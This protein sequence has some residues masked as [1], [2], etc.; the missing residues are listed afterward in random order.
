MTSILMS[1]FVNGTAF[2]FIFDLI[3]QQISVM[4]GVAWLF[5]VAW[6]VFLVVL[7]YQPDAGRWEL[8]DWL[9][10]AVF[11]VPIV[12]IPVYLA[13][14]VCRKQPPR[15]RPWLPW[16]VRVMYVSIILAI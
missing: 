10:T 4:L 3:H 1:S 11:L 5:L 15:L 7:V 12:V 8:G 6:G 16:S 9:M 14:C 13:N 2:F